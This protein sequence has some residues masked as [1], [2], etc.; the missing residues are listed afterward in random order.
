[1]NFCKLMFKFSDQFSLTTWR[2][3]SYVATCKRPTRCFIGLPLMCLPIKAKLHLQ[4]VRE[5]FDSGGRK[6]VACW[7][8]SFDSLWI[9]TVRPLS[10]WMIMICVSRPALSWAAVYSGINTSSV[11]FRV[12]FL[13]VYVHE[14]CWQ[15]R[16]HNHQHTSQNFSGLSSPL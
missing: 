12:I 10:K 1:M 14:C 7:R 13:F 16:Q 11:V 15:W 2:Q 3:I 6:L 8:Y 5:S 9:T 4:I